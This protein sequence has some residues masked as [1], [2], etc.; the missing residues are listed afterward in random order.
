MKLLVVGLAF[1]WLAHAQVATLV[2]D[3]EGTLD[4]GAGKLPLTL[5]A[6]KTQDGL[7]LGKLVSVDQGKFSLV[8]QNL[9]RIEVLGDKETM[10]VF[11]GKDD[12][13]ARAAGKLRQLD[14]AA[15]AFSGDGRTVP[16][17]RGGTSL[18]DRFV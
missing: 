15:F 1:A 17:G 8:E 13:R 11:E 3:W 5:H 7:Y 16:A 9:T 18:P 4:T 12:A 2:G 14:G 10:A 6:T